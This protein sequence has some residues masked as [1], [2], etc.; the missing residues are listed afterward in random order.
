MA[1]NIKNYN[2]SEGK[3][4]SGTAI[5]SGFFTLLSKAIRYGFAFLSQ[6]ILMNFL[7]PDDFGLMRYVAIVLGIV[8]MISEAGLG[9]AIVQKR[10]LDGNEASSS[11]TLVTLFSFILYGGLFMLAPALATFFS[12]PSLTSLIRV[13]CLGAPIGGLSIVQR[14]LMQRNFRYARLSLLEALGAVA[15]ST[16][17]IILGCTGHGVWSLVWSNLVYTAVSS[18]LS[19]L[20][21]GRISGKY[22]DFRASTALWAFG[23]GVVVQRMIDYLSSNIDY[24]VIG[25]RFGEISLGIYSVA[26][27]V[28]SL[29]QLALGAVLANVT[30]SAFSVFRDDD[31]RVHAAFIRLTK[32]IVVVSVPWFIIIF[33]CAPELM[34]AISFIKHGD[35][36]VPAAQ[37]IRIYAP[38]GMLYCLN[39]YPGTVWIAKGLSGFRIVWASVSLVTMFIAVVVGSFYGISGIC[40]AVLIR[41]ILMYPVSIYIN[42]YTF[43]LSPVKYMK[44]VLP[45]VISGA[46]TLFTVLV[47]CR[48]CHVFQNAGVYVKIASVCFL[49]FAV[50][51]VMIYFLS[52]ETFKEIRSVLAEI[53]CRTF[54]SR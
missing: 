47:F 15:G 25:K 9:V 4:L 40:Y 18:L 6:L 17:G 46:A 36:W 37:Y 42:K 26:F 7:C 23:S 22:L 29:P 32:L 33:V 24:I 13:G 49:C 27:M 45:P 31:E 2:I 12:S 52:R 41:A 8:N 44:A 3:P 21:I 50:Y 11:V 43:G 1:Y 10:S 16:T 39:S 54:T 53:M 5:R 19:I 20:S 34:T 30:T 14:G 48:V 28:M 51:S 38:V 35:K